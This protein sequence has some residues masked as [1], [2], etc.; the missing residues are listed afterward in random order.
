MPFAS[1]RQRR[2]MHANKPTMAK[3]WER[4]TPKGSKLPEKASEHGAQNEPERVVNDIEKGA[5]KSQAAKELARDIATILSPVPAGMV[6][7]GGAG[8]GIGALA[9]PEGRRGEGALKGLEYGARIGGSLGL[10]TGA[11][12]SV[13]GLAGEAVPLAP[14]IPIFSPMLG[15]VAGGMAGAR[16]R[17]EEAKKKTASIMFAACADELRSILS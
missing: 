5:S 3:Q 11:A 10:L 8:A 6:A 1:E 2:W 9:A 14:P 13:R 15:G 17:E 12:R 7:G 16:M 4:E